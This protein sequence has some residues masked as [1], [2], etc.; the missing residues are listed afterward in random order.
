MFFKYA[1]LNSSR[2]IFLTPLH[3]IY[4]STAKIR[5]SPNAG[6]YPPLLFRYFILFYAYFILL[7][8]FIPMFNYLIL[9]LT[10]TQ[11]IVTLE[12]HHFEHYYHV[13]AWPAVLLP[14]RMTVTVSKRIEKWLFE[15]TVPGR[16]ARWPS[17]T[18]MQ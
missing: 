15:T 17:R 8:A 12:H 5:N 10:I 9:S 4:S 1:F 3:G 18:R 6:S 7:G 11:V 2:E 16:A 13:Y 14:S